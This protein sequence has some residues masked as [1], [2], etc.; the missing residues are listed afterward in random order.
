MLNFDDIIVNYIIF[1]ALVL[2]DCT[3]LNYTHPPTSYTYMLN[4]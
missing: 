1:Y 4:F 3:I 2:K